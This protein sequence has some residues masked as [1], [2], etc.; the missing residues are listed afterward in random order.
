M[1]TKKIMFF[2]PP[3]YFSPIY[4]GLAY[5]LHVTPPSR[6]DL[7]YAALFPFICMREHS[8]ADIE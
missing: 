1:A 5:F 4:G 6:M 3:P 7:P 2:S 8:L